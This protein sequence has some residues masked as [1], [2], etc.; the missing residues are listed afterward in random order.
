MSSL[1]ISFNDAPAPSA[2]REEAEKSFGGGRNTWNLAA[3]P[4]HPYRD[5]GGGVGGHRTPSL[6]RS[7]SRAWYR[8]SPVFWGFSLG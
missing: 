5:L 8:G 7:Q 2:L 6:D 3:V 4:P 1:R